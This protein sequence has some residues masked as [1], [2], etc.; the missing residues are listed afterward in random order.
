MCGVDGIR[1]ERLDNGY[2]VHAEGPEGKGG[3]RGKPVR[4]YA[5]SPEH[6]GK[7][8]AKHLGRGRRAGGRYRGHARGVHLSKGKAKK[9]KAMK[10]APAAV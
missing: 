6:A 2:V 5:A 1:I 4:H 9:R 8:V 7:A 3:E 10:D